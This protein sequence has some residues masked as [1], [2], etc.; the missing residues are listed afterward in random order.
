MRKLLG[1]VLMMVAMAALARTQSI[2]VANPNKP[3]VVRSDTPQ[4]TITLPANRT[5]GYSWFIGSYDKNLVQPVSHQYKELQRNVPGAPGESVWTFHILK[6]AFTAP[7][8]IRI[9]MVYRRPWE[10][11]NARTKVITIITR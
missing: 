1:I 11:A 10:S 4:V 7:H 6:A 3:I 8:A 9:K 2:T 5:T